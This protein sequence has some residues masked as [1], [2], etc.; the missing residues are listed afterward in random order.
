MAAQKLFRRT[1][2]TED[3]EWMDELGAALPL[4]FPLG[5][6]F[7]FSA[8]PPLM[9]HAHCSLQLPFLIAS[10]IEKQKLMAR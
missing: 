3:D 2:Y 7:F 10:S 4:F 5:D 6:H 9:V 1:H 8:F